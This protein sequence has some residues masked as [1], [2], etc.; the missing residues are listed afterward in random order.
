MRDGPV[1]RK[2]RRDFATELHDLVRDRHV[3]D[4]TTCTTNDGC[5]R[6]N[7]VWLGQLSG[8]LDEVEAILSTIVTAWESVPD[9][10]QVPDEIDDDALWAEARRVLSRPRPEG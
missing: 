9:N 7:A 8:H 10:V 2:K 5:R 6:V 1:A 3:P 4:V